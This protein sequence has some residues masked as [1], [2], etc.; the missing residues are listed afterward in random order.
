MNGGDAVTIADE[1]PP[2][3][4]L[5][6]VADTLPRRHQAP[7]PYTLGE[8]VAELGRWARDARDQPWKADVNV[9]SL[10][11]DVDA[12]VAQLGPRLHALFSDLLPLLSMSADRNSLVR[13]CAEFLTRWVSPAT[14]GLAFRDLCEKA[15]DATSTTQALRVSA[16]ILASQLNDQGRGLGP[17]DQARRVLSDEFDERDLDFHLGREATEDDHAPAAR[18]V[19][20]DQMLQEPP[21]VGEVTVWTLYRR[22]QVTWRTAAGPIVFLR[23][24]WAIPNAREDDGQL[25]EERDEL[26]ALLVDSLVPSE[27]ILWPEGESRESYVLVRIQLGRRNAIDAAEEA[28]RRIEAILNIAAGSGGVIW[29]ATGSSATMLDGQLRSAS[30]GAHVRDRTDLE[31]SYGVQQTM[32]LIA[33]WSMRLSDALDRGPMPEFLMDALGAVREAS[34]TDH[35]DVHFYDARPVTPRVALAL[36]DHAMEQVA[37]LAQMKPDL[38]IANLMEDEVDHLWDQTVSAAVWAPL[39]GRR[40]DPNEHRE[41]LRLQAAIVRYGGGGRVLE[42]EKVWALRSELEAFARD[43]AARCSLLAGLAAISDAAEEARVRDVARTEGAVVR[44]RHRRVRNAIVHG[45]PVS[46][47]AMASVS[48]FSDR[49]TRNALGIALESYAT[50]RTVTDLLDDRDVARDAQRTSGLSMLDRLAQAPKS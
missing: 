6:S 11:A 41:Q 10:T 47:A 24:D 19:L 26:R 32:S 1:F 43:T 34:L 35:R 29:V 12:G 17:L 15:S 2:G 39:A 48:D 5:R 37:S 44:S 45:N 9:R 23:A 21:P 46:S 31:D 13:T 36:Q 42:V 3:D 18:L 25:F 30:F 49:I 50:G 38:L 20:V 27:D 28:E 16:D 14:V 7:P 40:T 4:W 33:S 8:T 22:A